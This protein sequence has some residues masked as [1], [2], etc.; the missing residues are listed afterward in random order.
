MGYQKPRHYT[1]D[2]LLAAEIADLKTDIRCAER[3]GLPE[4]AEQCR[5]KLAELHKKCQT[6]YDI[7]D[8]KEFSGTIEQFEDCF[9]GVGG[10]PAG[11]R[12]FCDDMGWKLTTQQVPG[13]NPYPTLA[14]NVALGYIDL[15]SN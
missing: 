12:A 2:E 3:D 1:D 4:Y 15:L 13:S 11:I 7:N 6:I 14:E 9:G 5:A 10:D 8:G